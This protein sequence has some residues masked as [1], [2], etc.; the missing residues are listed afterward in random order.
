MVTWWD[1]VGVEIQQLKAEVI[2]LAEGSPDTMR[3]CIYSDDEGCPVCIVGQAVFNITGQVVSNDDWFGGI[4]GSAKWINA[5]GGDS[6]LSNNGLS[7]EDYDA[8][9]FVSHVQNR[10][11]MGF[12]W[13]EALNYAKER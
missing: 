2:R 3:A 5:F 11:D 9:L 1:G 10:Q 4:D 8:F 13:G 12:T 6:T 7:E